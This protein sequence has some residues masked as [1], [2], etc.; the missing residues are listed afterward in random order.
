MKATRLTVVLT[1]MSAV[2]VGSLAGQA[3]TAASSHAATIL[4]EAGGITNKLQDD[5]AAGRWDAA[6]NKLLALQR[7]VPKLDSLDEAADGGLFEDRETGPELP[8]LIDSLA[9]RLEDGRRLPALASANAVGRA[10]LPLV[11]AFSTPAR[12][13]VAH[14]DVAARDLQYSAERGSWDKARD[15]LQE[16]R[17]TYDILQPQL[18][19]RAPNLNATIERR[20]AD[21]SGALQGHL[22]VRAHKLAGEFLEDVDLIQ[23]T[24]TD[25]R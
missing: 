4:H 10:L 19:Q 9:G 3:A 14:L 18:V 24:F 17:K 15:A 20:L 5:V 8:M 12:L 16:I 21:L 2:L 22:H 13:A 7:L 1:V 23:S 11:A 25:D 6:R